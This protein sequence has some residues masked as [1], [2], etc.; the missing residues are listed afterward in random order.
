MKLDQGVT[1]DKI[2]K[3]VMALPRSVQFD[4]PLALKQYKTLRKPVM[5]EE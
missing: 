2:S 1:A 5:W 4:A 3:Y